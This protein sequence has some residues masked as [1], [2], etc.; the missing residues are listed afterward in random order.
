[1][2]LISFSESQKSIIWQNN[3]IYQNIPLGVWGGHR[4]IWSISKKYKGTFG[5]GQG[6]PGSPCLKNVKIPKVPSNFGKALAKSIP[7]VS[8]TKKVTSAIILYLK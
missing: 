2:Y 6:V 1:M 8:R 3:I 5:H 7:P 4:K